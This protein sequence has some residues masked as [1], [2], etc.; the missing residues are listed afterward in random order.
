MESSINKYDDRL[1]VVEASSYSTTDR[2]W[3]SSI[4]RERIYI[5]YKHDRRMHTYTLSI[6]ER[7]DSISVTDILQTSE[8]E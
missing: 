7:I 5:C 3:I 6:D 4:Q 1:Y 8:N 2:D